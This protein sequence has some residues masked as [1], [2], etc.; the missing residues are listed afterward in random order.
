MSE[1]HIRTL[2]EMISALDHVERC[3]VL[4]REELEEAVG[5]ARA[6][7]ETGEAGLS[8]V[9]EALMEGVQSTARGVFDCGVLVQMVEET[10]AKYLKMG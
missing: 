8:P 7:G 3:I 10:R 1:T 2:S 9:G 4:L 5:E 6:S